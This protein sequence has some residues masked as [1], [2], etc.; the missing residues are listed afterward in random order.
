M[1]S[2]WLTFEKLI[3]ELGSIRAFADEAENF[4]ELADDPVMTHVR[5]R[6]AE[7][8]GAISRTVGD[9]TEQLEDADDRLIVDAWTA[10][11]RAQDAVALA[12]KAVEEARE[13]RR[14][15]VLLCE[16][17]RNHRENT[18]RLTESLADPKSRKPVNEPQLD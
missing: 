2:R 16:Q 10:L 12:R 7:A 3:R 14:R 8:T 9:F 6:M 4:P 17:A 5:V 15:A 1:S 18:Q 13:M 11:A